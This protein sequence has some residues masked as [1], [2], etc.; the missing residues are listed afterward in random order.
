MVKEIT[1]AVKASNGLF[2]LFEKDTDNN[3]ADKN[4]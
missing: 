1:F 2:F 3:S 4:E